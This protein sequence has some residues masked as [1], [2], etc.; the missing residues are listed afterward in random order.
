MTLILRKKCLICVYYPMKNYQYILSYPFDH[1]NNFYCAI[2]ASLDGVWISD[3]S[4]C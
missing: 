2:A 3:A 1:L 4:W